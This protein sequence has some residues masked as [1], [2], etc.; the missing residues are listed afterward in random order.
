M[1]VRT[2]RLSQSN[3]RLT[4]NLVLSEFR[5]PGHDIVIIDDDLAPTMERIRDGISKYFNIEVS[6]TIVNSGYRT[7]AYDRKVGGTGAGPHTVGKAADFYF[8]NKAGRAINSIYGLCVAQLLGIKGIE[9]IRDGVSIHI[10]VNYRSGFWW[11][12]QAVNAAGRFVY[13]MLSDFFSSTWA[14]ATPPPP[15]GDAI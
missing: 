12:W 3:P 7:A 6:A 5:T 14:R 8:R 10:D 2:Y 9:R 4:K 15:R 13:H 11:V 1:A